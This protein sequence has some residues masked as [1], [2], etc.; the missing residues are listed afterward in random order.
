[1][2]FGDNTSPRAAACITNLAV[3][4]MLEVYGRHLY[5]WKEVG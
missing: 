2:S 1:M 4:H 5:F 3:V